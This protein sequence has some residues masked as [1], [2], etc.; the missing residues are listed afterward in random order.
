MRLPFRCLFL[1]SSPH[2]KTL[3]K[4]KTL[5]VACLPRAQW[6]MMRWRK[7]KTSLRY[8]VHKRFVTILDLF[9]Y[10]NQSTSVFDCIGIIAL[11]RPGQHLQWRSRVRGQINTLQLGRCWGSWNQR[12]ATGGIVRTRGA[13]SCPYHV[14]AVRTARSGKWFSSR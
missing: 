4:R 8:L 1:W 14:C 5:N 2:I 9:A 13:D 7:E 3:L 6:K 11:H 10:P 12:E